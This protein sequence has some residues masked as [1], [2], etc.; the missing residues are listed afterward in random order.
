M[1][2]NSLIY[3]FLFLIGNLFCLSLE[4]WPTYRHDNRR[5]GVTSETPKLPL[6]LNWVRLSKLP[7]MMAWS[8]PAK[9]DAYSG[10]KDLQSM[11]NFDPVFYVTISNKLV[12]FGSSIDNS[13]HCLNLNNGNEKW[14]S[15]TSG[16]VRLPPS[17]NS[18]K[19]YF[20]SDDGHVYCVESVS[21]KFNWKYKPL[22]KNRFIASNGKLISSY[23]I[24]TGILVQG[25]SVFFGASLVPWENSYL[26]SLNKINGSELFVSTHTNMTLQGAFL[27]SSKTI[28]APQGRSVPLLFDIQNGKSIKSLSNTGGT[29]CLLTPDDKF[30]A[31]PSNQKSSGNMIQ[32]ADASG[33]SAMIKFAGA[34]R[35]LISNEHVYIHQQGKLRSLD[36]NKYSNSNNKISSN[37]GR[38]KK[39][40]EQLKETK[41]K[42]P[43]LKNQNQPS[44][45]KNSLDLISQMQMS[46]NKIKLSNIKEQKNLKNS[47]SW[48][49]DTSAPY[50]LILAD[51]ILFHGGL[52]KVSAFNAINGDEVWSAEIKGKAYGLAFS[53]GTLLV[54]TTLGHIYAFSP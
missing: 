34:D 42:L 12:Y 16:A 25:E 21:G 37:N 33:S 41:K 31:M 3:F 49:V 27:A 48:G 38:A 13:I 11:R 30:V 52:D 9:W 2:K 5:S 40:E 47:F 22:K 17:I 19:C 14:V 18:G 7:P 35:L 45:Y 54:S 23:P 32:I 20:G 43:N 24:R 44:K 50:D 6:K 8:G 29:F 15:F 46:L 36:R 10:N 26:C 28:Y 4:D 53:H 1:L 39:L 51:N